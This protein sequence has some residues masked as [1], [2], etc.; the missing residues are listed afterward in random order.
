MFRSLSGI[1]NNYYCFFKSRILREIAC[2]R[3]KKLPSNILLVI[4]GLKSLIS[5]ICPYFCC[6]GCLIVQQHMRCHNF[7]HFIFF[8]CLPVLRI[9]LYW[10]A[11]VIFCRLEITISQRTSRYVCELKTNR[12]S[13][14]KHSHDLLWIKWMVVFDGITKIG[15]NIWISPSWSPSKL[16]I[17][18][19]HPALKSHLNLS[20]FF[21]LYNDRKLCEPKL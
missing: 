2:S 16:S 8:S 7:I 12:C 15:L 5:K 9:F 10:I 11:L 17:F 13:S 6:P 19:L 21:F 14:V 4:T 3:Q 18:F 20:V 1:Q